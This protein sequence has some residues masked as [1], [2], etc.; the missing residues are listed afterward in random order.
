MNHLKYSVQHLSPTC[1]QSQ[2]P[3]PFLGLYL[4]TRTL[5][6]LHYLPLT[7]SLHLESKINRNCGMNCG[8]S[9]YEG[10]QSE[11]QNIVVLK[12]PLLS[13]SNVL[14]HH[15]NSRLSCFSIPTGKSSAPSDT[16]SLGSTAFHQT[17]HPSPGSPPPL[18]LLAWH[19][20]CRYTSDPDVRVHEKHGQ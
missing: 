18:L 8:I 20:D 5:M 17:P 7:R 6:M 12:S 9:K 3:P 16:C 1:W 14:P 19:I 11:V 15:P 13:R 2:L 4:R 10:H